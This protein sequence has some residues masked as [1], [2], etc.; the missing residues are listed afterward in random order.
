MVMSDK[1]ILDAL[2]NEMLIC[3]ARAI[4][5]EEAYKQH[6]MVSEK[7]VCPA[8]QTVANTT[9]GALSGAGQL[10]VWTVAETDVLVDITGWIGPDGSSR[11]TPT[12]PTRVVDTRSG[13]G[14]SRLGAGSTMSVDFSGL[15]PA[16]TSAVALNVTG[17]SSL[18]PGF[19]TVF[20][21]GSRPNTSTVNYV[22]N[23]ARPN[24]TIV[25]L[26]AGRVC[27]F[28]DQSTE[29][30]V[31]LL[32]AFGASGLSYQPTAPIRVLDTRR[33]GRLGAGQAVG[34]GVGAASLGGRSPG[35]AYV[36]VTAANHLVPGY[37]TT[38][39]CIT[40][41]NTSTVNQKVGQAAANG[42]IVP[43]DALRSC[44]WTFGGG[45]LIVDLNGWWV[46]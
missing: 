36:H 42:A 19:I 13:Q 37:V 17:V 9:I 4:G 39:D 26:T 2:K 6:F 5:A 29:I 16:G 24:N 21:C 38:Y 23:E 44:A 45:D 22:A 14:G 28:S 31:D 25:G 7:R 34:Y 33:T 27:I 32:G 20:P 18:A 11:L 1:E 30:L 43:L 8:G 3:K 40:R 10:C 15:V 41:R 35:A 12:G 46:P